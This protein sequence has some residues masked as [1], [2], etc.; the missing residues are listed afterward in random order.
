MSKNESELSINPIQVINRLRFYQQ[1]HGL[2]HQDIAEKIGWDRSKVQRVFFGKQSQHLHNLCLEISN[3][4]NWSYEWI[5][6]GDREGESNSESIEGK[7]N[8]RLT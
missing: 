6:N 1:K 8:Q 7:G 4:Y 2:S 3:A 5:I